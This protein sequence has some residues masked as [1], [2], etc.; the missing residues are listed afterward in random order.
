MNEDL[1]VDITYMNNHVWFMVQTWGGEK[2]IKK[3][4]I[5]LV[6]HFK[7][8]GSKTITSFFLN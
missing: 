4:R 1:Y 6:D 8:K 3:S 5:F 7:R 2:L